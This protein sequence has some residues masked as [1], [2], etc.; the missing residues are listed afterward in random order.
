[1]AG[2]GTRTQSLGEFKPFIEIKGCKMFCWFISSIKHLVKP[3]DEFVLIT[4][5]YFY[6]K[7]Q[8]EKVAK[9]IFKNHKL[10]NK[11]HFI[12]ADTTP[13]GMSATVYLAKNIIAANKEVMVICPDQYIDFLLPIFEPNTAYLGVYAQL[14]D[15]SGFMRIDGHWVTKFVEKTNIS[16]L[17]SAGFYF[18]PSGNDLIGA[19]EKQFKKDDAL[20]GEYYLGPVFNF[21]IKKGIP[22]LPLPVIAKY[23]LG[24]PECINYFKTKPFKCLC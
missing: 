16:N 22:V 20:N 18:V 23:D 10:N 12:T 14:G 9:N 15:K 1:M 19:I 21:L 17:A 13:K 6:D 5:K 8:F 2:K 7:Y 24:N 11:V 4:L 3:D